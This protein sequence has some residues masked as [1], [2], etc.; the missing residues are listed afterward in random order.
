M[1]RQ[2][3]SSSG[4]FTVPD[5]SNP[6]AAS[7]HT[8]KQLNPRSCV[9]C[10]RR[11]VRCNKRTP[12]SNCTKAGI[13]CVFP[14]PGRAPRKSKR[15]Q[16]A[17]LLSRLRRLEGVI[18]QIREKK[19]ESVSPPRQPQAADTSLANKDYEQPKQQ[20][21]TVI[22][23]G[24]RES[25]GRPNEEIDCPYMFEPP[26]PKAVKPHN[27]GN[28]FG[29]L[30]IDEGR[31]RYVS[32]RLW[33]SLGDEIEEM[34]DILDPSS[35]DEDDYPSPDSSTNSTGHD[36]FLLGFYSLSHSLR[37]YHPNPEYISVLWNVYLE[38]VAPLITILHTPTLKK[39]F[40]GPAQNPNLLDKNSEALVFT[41]Y[42]VSIIS[43][44]SENCQYLLGD[45]RDV[46]VS[47]YR[48]AVE[49]A[50]AKANLLNT[51]NLM[52]LQAAVIFLIGV[53]R[54]DDTK[55]VWAMTAVILRLA[56][57]LGLHR[58]GTNFGLKPFETEMRR[59]LWWHV[60][61]LDT[62]ASEDH[63]T[64][65]QIHER[66]YDT[67][68]PLNIND[69]DI[70]PDMKEPPTEREGATQMTF[71][72][73]RF[74][75]TA[76]LRR[77]SYKCPTGKLPIGNA[78]PPIETC[79]NLIQVVNRRM[80]ERYIKHCD[81]NVPIYWVCAT[82]AR[83]ILAKLW[84]IIHHPMTRHDR[85]AHISQV[86][87]ENL[88][89]TSIEVIEFSRLLETNEHTSKWGWLFR[90]N[91]QWHCIAFV[92][93][94]LCVRPLCPITDR[95]WYVVNS[96]YSAWE[97]QANHKKGML[98]RPLSRLMKR[99]AAIR[100]KQQQE[101]RVGPS[102]TVSDRSL[103][104][105]MQAGQTSVDPHLPQFLPQMK[106][107]LDLPVPVPTPIPLE[108]TSS[109]QVGMSL[110][111]LDLTKGA[112][113]AVNDLFPN[114]DWLAM[115]P[116]SEPPLSGAEMPGISNT[117]TTSIE[118]EQNLANSQLN[119]EEWDQVMRDFQMDLQRNETDQPLGKVSDWLA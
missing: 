52:L 101:M 54:E 22:G 75:I 63:G 67:Q 1:P 38:N 106:L 91:M 111:E 27:I 3:R 107:D 94:E 90:T 40:D 116:T 104:L 62:R 55:F 18:E 80:E 118:H 65:V 83:L 87:R 81:M 115:D 88:F 17:E 14:A 69:E 112:M 96:V 57:G 77:V 70:S 82:V 41:V 7:Q 28:E 68:L 103:S 109:G 46:L 117:S 44:T 100:T 85:K 61:L 43:M 20:S 2:H 72:L 76:A 34:Q 86:S 23:N 5:N 102:S 39:L 13:E 92:L 11:K 71:S 15:P 6:N 8:Q 98:W 42:F 48:F 97:R 74:E 4:S 33:A 12:C 110:G 95:G 26:D 99:A 119:W 56:Q 31:S 108:D 19:E 37:G 16:D 10:R 50:L 29:R 25:N 78:Q 58:D 66:M 64:D 114:P 53:R 21:T 35:S 79:G 93:S 60:C 51:Q 30:V 49:Q 47:R 113:G 84:L 32:N 36:G 73:I 9:T 59:R 89:L 105:P 45:S 24:E